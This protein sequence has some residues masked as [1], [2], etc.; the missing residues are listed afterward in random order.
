MFFSEGDVKGVSQHVPAIPR[1]SSVFVKTDVSL[2]LLFLS[3][4][5]PETFETL[6]SY[7]VFPFSLAYNWCKVEK[8]PRSK[9]VSL[10]NPKSI[11]LGAS[12]NVIQRRHWCNY[13]FMITHMT[14]AGCLHTLQ[15]QTFLEIGSH[16][17]ALSQ[18]VRRVYYS[19]QHILR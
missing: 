15:M 11:T 14:F 6:L 10:L 3:T 13:W 19:L 5:R 17:A 9:L 7:L 4:F 1:K 8:A 18:S 2:I 12:P 16:F